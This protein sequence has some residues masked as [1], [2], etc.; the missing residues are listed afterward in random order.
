VGP[1]ADDCGEELLAAILAND[2]RNTRRPFVAR[3]KNPASRMLVRG[4]L[5]V[6][7]CLSST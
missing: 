4:P 3:A 6:N 2:I 7:D 5:L 1:K